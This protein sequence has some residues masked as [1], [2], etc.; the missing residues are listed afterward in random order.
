MAYYYRCKMW[1]SCIYIRW[2]IC[3]PGETRGHNGLTPFNYFPECLQSLALYNTLLGGE[4][5]DRIDKGGIMS[6]R[7]DNLNYHQDVILYMETANYMYILR[8]VKPL[9][10]CVFSTESI[11]T[12]DLAVSGPHII[13]SI[14]LAQL[15]FYLIS[16]QITLW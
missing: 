16:F 9:L 5:N 15:T 3:S 7:N 8:P 10:T 13:C 4:F 11:G 6:V 14:L 2:L 1:I 12:E